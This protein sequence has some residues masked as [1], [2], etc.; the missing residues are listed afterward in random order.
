MPLRVQILSFRHTQFSK[1]NCLRSQCPPY[2]LDAP[3]REILDPP[4]QGVTVEN[5]LMKLSC[6]FKKSRSFLFQAKVHILI[7]NTNNITKTK[8]FHYVL[9]AVTDPRFPARG[10]G[11]QITTWPFFGKYAVADPEF[12]VGGGVDLVGGDVDS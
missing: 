2:E 9:I 10:G 11:H 8:Y 7:S 3:L 6:F 5:K 4:L 1:L 12:P